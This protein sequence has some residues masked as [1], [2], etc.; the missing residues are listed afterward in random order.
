MKILLLNGGQTF[1][2]S[3][4]Q[5]NRT[6]H[7]VAKTCLSELGHTI[8]ETHIESGYDIENEVK[9]FLWADT[10]IYQMPG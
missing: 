5:L 9:K 6:L 4:G 10:I 3:A 1:A 7:D 2:H 8:Q